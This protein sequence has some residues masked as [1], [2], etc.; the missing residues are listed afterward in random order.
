MV[1]CCPDVGIYKNPKITEHLEINDVHFLT[2]DKTMIES[3]EDT[4]SVTKHNDESGKEILATL[5]MEKTIKMMM[6]DII[7]QKMKKYHIMT[8]CQY[9][10]NSIMHYRGIKNIK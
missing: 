1:I 8:R 6:L 3:Y 2:T 5:M 4:I 10:Q 7:P 9:H